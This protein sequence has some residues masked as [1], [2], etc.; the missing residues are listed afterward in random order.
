MVH[1]GPK[2][3]RTVLN[4]TEKIHVNLEFSGT[5]VP[6]G[7]GIEPS[8]PL[9]IHKLFIPRLD[10]IRKNAR[11]RYTKGTRRLK[12][13]AAAPNRLG[14]PW[15]MCVNLPRLSIVGAVNDPSR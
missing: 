4:W 6:R 1:F 5:S 15:M 12:D 11:L 7:G 8:A 10:K 3:D 14:S 2:L 9:N 13:Y